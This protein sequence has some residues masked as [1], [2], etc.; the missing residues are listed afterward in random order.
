MFHLIYLTPSRTRFFRVPAGQDLP[1]GEFVVQT[2]DKRE[3]RVSEEALREFEIPKEEA[4]ALLKAE[5]DQAL[6]QAWGAFKNVASAEEP[7][8]VP[9]L[10][11][12]DLL[13]DA[14]QWPKGQELQGE[15]LTNGLHSLLSLL[16]ETLAVAASDDPAT[17]AQAEQRIAALRAKLEGYGFAVD[18]PIE[19]LPAKLAVWRE[20][21]PSAAEQEQVATLLGQLK[22]LSERLEVKSEH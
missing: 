20:A 18:K 4:H 11:A 3:L 15:H 17:Q 16:S 14:L 8:A 21:Q 1:P 9:A 19:D 12:E 5:M 7:G 10:R 2:L 22:V 6:R 13:R